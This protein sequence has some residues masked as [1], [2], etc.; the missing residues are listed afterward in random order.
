MFISVCSAFNLKDHVPVIAT[1]AHLKL[2]QIKTFDL[3]GGDTYTSK[4]DKNIDVK[5]LSG[6]LNFS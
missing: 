4:I 3:G 5:Q 6:L 1:G 2:L